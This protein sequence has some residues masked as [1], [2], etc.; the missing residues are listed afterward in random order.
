MAEIEKKADELINARRPITTATTTATANSNA[1]Q[2]EQQSALVVVKNIPIES[3]FCD[4]LYT[5]GSVPLPYNMLE[6][7]LGDRVVNLTNPG[8]PFGFKGTVVT[9][10]K[11]TKYVEVCYFNSK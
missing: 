5:V 8:T 10:H 6:P 4:A 1:T 7:K 11:H 3:L 9:I 2:G